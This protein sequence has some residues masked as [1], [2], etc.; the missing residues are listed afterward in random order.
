MDSSACCIMPGVLQQISFMKQ[1][2][3]VVDA[4]QQRSSGPQ[5]CNQE[6]ALAGVEKN[7]CCAASCLTHLLL[8]VRGNSLWH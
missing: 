4:A 3:E 6:P 2:A 1:H 5:H 7:H 8:A